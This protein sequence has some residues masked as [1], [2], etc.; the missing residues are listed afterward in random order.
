VFGHRYTKNEQEA[1][2]DE[3]ETE[4]RIADEMRSLEADKIEKADPFAA[5]E[6]PQQ[7]QTSGVDQCPI[8]R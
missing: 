1:C 2:R 4:Q 7:R 3:R 6:S 5:R 8:D